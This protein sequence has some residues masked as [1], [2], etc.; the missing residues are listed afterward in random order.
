[1]TDATA[2]LAELAALDIHLRVEGGRLRYD[3]PAGVFS[4]ALKARVRSARSALMGHLAGPAPL[5]SGQERMWFLNRLEA[6]AGAYTEHLA[7]DLRGPLDLAALT[8]AV[9][10][11]VARHVPLRT[12]FRDSPSGAT[13]VPAA[14][15]PA[16]EVVPIA[17]GGLADRL[18]ILAHCAFDLATEAP[19]RFTLLRMAD[20]HHVLSVAAHHA[21]WDGWSNGVFLA[22]LAELYTARRQGRPPS[23][24]EIAVDIPTLARAERERLGTAAAQATVARLAQACQGFPTVLSLPTDRPR[25]AVADGRGA[26]L[27]VRVSAPVLAALD[28]AGRQVSATSYMV[29]LAAWALT[30]AR[31]TG[32]RRLLVGAPVAGRDSA[33]AEALIGYLSNT[34]VF[35][36]DLEGAADFATLVGRVRQAVLAG[37]DTQSVP[38][39]ALVEALAPPRSA[40]TTPLVQTVFALQPAPVTAP[41]LVGLE[42]SVLPDGN[43]AARYELML[44]LLPTADGG[45]EGSLIHATALLDQATVTRW[46]DQFLATL[47]DVPAAW[48]RPLDLVLQAAAGAAG[49]STPDSVV[50]AAGDFATGTERRLAGVWAEFLEAARIGRDDDFFLLGGHSLLLMRMVHRLAEMGLGRLSLADALANTRLSAMAAVLDRRTRAAPSPPVVPDVIAEEAPASPAQEGL[51]LARRDDPDAAN[52]MVPSLIPLDAGVGEAELRSALARLAALH[53]ALRTT[54]VEREGQVWQRVAVPGPVALDVQ[55][56]MDGERAAAFLRA[57]LARPFDLSRG[58][59]YRFHLLRGTTGASLYIV[60]DHIVTDGWSQELLA[61]DL[62]TLLAGGHPPAPEITPIAQAQAHR[63]LLAG[64]E[65]A[66]LAEYWRTA[67]DGMVLGDPPGALGRRPPAAARRG[68]KVQVR[69]EGRQ[70]RVLDTIAQGA[71]TT[72]TA[73][74]AAVVATLLARLKG[75]GREV[76]V[77]LPFACRTAPEMAGVVGCY[78]EVLPIRLSAGMDQP[79]QD[80]LVAAR[81]GIA[82]AIAHQD[83]PLSSIIADRARSGGGDAG[84]LFDA[85]VVYDDA[86]PGQEDWFAPDLNTGKYDLAFILSRLPDGGG[87]LAV[88]YDSWLYDEADARAFIDR[89]AVLMADIG[90]RPQAP[91]G[92]LEILPPAERE[93]VVG[94]FNQTALDYPRD[95]DLGSLWRSAAARHATR[96]A[97]TGTDGVTLSYAELEQRV[98]AL[99]AALAGVVGDDAAVGLALDRGA[100]AVIA[101]LALTRLGVAYLP[102]DAKLPVDAV[103]RLMADAGAR[104]VLADDGAAQRLADLGGPEGGQGKDGAAVV[105]LDHVPPA[106]T[107]ARD[108]APM[109]AVDGGS[110]AYIMF[111]SGS[112]GQ[113]KG[114]VVP[115]RG[116]ARLALDPVAVPITADDVVPQAAPLGFDAATLEIW[117]TLLNGAHLRIL[118]DDDLMDPAAL[119]ATLRQTGVSVL[120]L[121]AG[122]FNRVADEAPGAFATTRVVLTGG[123]TANPAQMARVLAACPGTRL[124]N[125][126]GPTENTTFTSVHAV[127]PADLADLAGAVP[128][129]RPIANTRVYLVDDRL[130]PVPVGVWGELL[131]AGDG[132][133]LGY[134][135][136]ADL[137]EASFVHLDWAGEERAYRS[138]DYAR[139]RHDGVLEFG[140]RRDGQVKIRGHRIET[141]A[142][143]AVLEEGADIR[144]AAVVVTGQGADRL[145]VACVVAD[146]AAA[147][148]SWRQRLGER[149]P[150]YMMPARFVLVPAL[151]VNR[152]GKVDRRAL[153][154]HVATLTTEPVVAPILA[155]PRQ[156]LVARVFTEFFPGVAIDGASDFMRLGGHSLLV[157]RL[158][159]RL[160]DE[161]GCRLPMRALFAARTVTAIAALLPAGTAPVSTGHRDAAAE[162]D[163]DATIPCQPEGMDHPLSPG[164]ERLI[165]LQR[166]FPG[167]GVYNVP[168]VFDVEGPLDQAAL[169]PAFV[170]L[171]TRHHALRLRIVDDGQAG[172]RQRLAAP[173]GLRPQWI[174]VAD[175]AAAQAYVEA[176]MMRPF[177]LGREGP[178]RAQVVRFGPERWRVLLVVHHAFCDGWSMA[179]LVRDLAAFYAV[180]TGAVGDAAVAGAPQRQMSDY[181][182]WQR[183]LAASPRGRATLARQVARL[184]PPPPPLDLPTD[185]RRPAVRGFKGGTL[186]HA[187]D[188]ALSDRLTALAHTHRAT[189]FALATALVQAL[190]YRLTGQTDLALG[191]LVAPRERPELADTVGFFVNTLVLRQAV[192]G[193]RPFRDHLA[194]TRDVCL[195]AMDDQHC[196]F[197][198]LVAAVDAPRDL[199]RNPL[200]DVLVV[201]QEAASAVPNLPGLRTAAVNLDFPMAKFDLAF[202]FCRRESGIACEIEYSAELFAPATITRLA[203]RLE[204][205]AR[206]VVADPAQTV[207]ALDLLPAAERALVVHGFNDTVRDLPVERII[208]APFLDRVAAAPAAPALVGDDFPAL[209]Y[210]GFARTAAR[211]AAR[212][213]EEGVGPGDVVGLCLPR[214]PGLLTAIFG[215]L[216]AGAAYA[217]LG[218]DQPPARLADMMDD[219][220]RPLVLA[221]TATRDRVAG[222]ARLLEID[223]ILGVDATTVPAADDWGPGPAG[224]DDL[225]YVLFTSGSTGRPKGVEI[226]HR[227]VLNRLWWMQGQFPIGAGDVVLQK[228]PVTFDVSVWELFWWS[229]TGAALALPPP[230]LERDP[231]GLAA[232]I[233]RHRVTVVHFVPSMLA[234][235]L[236]C[237][238]DGRVRISDLKTL[239]YVFASGEAL[240]PGLA[241]RFDRLLHRVHGTGLHNLYGPTEATVDVSW[242]PCTPWTGGGVPIG[243]PVANTRLYVLDGRGQPTPIGVAGE[244]HIGGVQVAR[245][246]RNRPDLTAERFIADPFAGGDPDARLYRTGDLGRWRADGSI[247]YLGRIDH[248]VKVR[249]QRIEPGEIEHALEAHPAVERA[250]VVPATNEGLTE[251]HAYLL[252]RRPV[253]PADL[254]A[255]LAGRLPEAMV[256]ARFFQMTHLPLTSS[257]KLDRKAL[258]GTPLRSAPAVPVPAI[259]PSI[260]VSA[261]ADPAALMAIESEIAG[262]WRALLPEAEFGPRDGFFTVGGNSLLV[263]RLHQRLDA[264]WPGVFAIADLFAAATVADQ[265]RR[266]AAATGVPA[267]PN[268]SVPNAVPPGGS[269]SPVTVS[270]PVGALPAVPSGAIAV[271]GLA[272]RVAGAETLAD[273]WTDVAAGVDRFRPL[274]AGRVADVHALYA[275]LGLPVPATFRQAAY[276]EEVLGFDCRRYRLSPADAALIDPEQRLFLDVALRALEDAGRGGT[277]LD[278]AKVGVFVGASGPGP[279]RAA[280]LRAVEPQR[281]EQA[282]ALTVPSNVATRLSFQHNWRGPAALVDTACSASLSAL[283]QGVR[284]LRSGDCDWALVGGAKAILLP[285]G[286][287]QRLTID[288]S[289][290]R[291][292]AFAEG[293]DGTGMGEGAV[294]L[295][296]RPLAAALAA[297]DPIHAVILGTAVNQD[298]ASSGMAAPNPTAQAEVIRAAAADAGVSLASLSYVEAHGTGTALGDPIEIQG[299]TTAFAADTAEVGFA[300]VGSAKGNY[301]HL[302]GAAGVLGLARAILSLTHDHAP[303]QPHFTAP[304]P[305]IAFDRAPVAVPRRAMALADRGGPRRAGISAFG[306]SGVNVHAVVEAAP[307]RVAAPATGRWMAVGL[308]AAEPEALHGYADAMVAALRAR[309][310][311]SLEEIART[312]TEGR[313]TLPARLAVAVRD[314]GDLMARLAVFVAAPAAAGD[315]VLVGVAPAGPPGARWAA[316]GPDQAAA[317]AAARAFVTGAVLTWDATDATTGRAHLPA[318]PW[319]GAA[320]RPICRRRRP[321]CRPRPVCSVRR[322]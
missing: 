79:F 183:A 16:L 254:V 207:D 179:L 186:V 302:D 252:L 152:N 267:T 229:W 177:D 294:A 8:A 192:A 36:I 25:G 52:W 191:T 248:Q 50:P 62:H 38:F 271:V 280:L 64:P 4:D 27:P 98:G 218:A 223:Q 94:R 320:W 176:E 17:A 30:L 37:L 293:A 85:V 243:R 296:L 22:E 65:G 263:I 265:A 154:R 264:R 93:R 19:A 284:A 180:G 231:V 66:R 26:A 273:L 210:R 73:A 208:T 249:G 133:A 55:D 299:L 321:W 277:A 259:A 268:L 253:G 311:W 106:P 157:M 61:R 60:A 87:L 84:S 288:S 116:V 63:T 70:G 213:R 143:E 290:G 127:T 49:P 144:A 307:A 46:R 147:E 126:Y 161:T 100:P 74:F 301:G 211:L 225:A 114:V 266:V 235:F 189:P 123:E 33:A 228:T 2:L 18:A 81:Q 23:L 1:M 278:D 67:L 286:E 257:G 146:D 238:E 3:A 237:V 291:T 236:A 134:A 115:H 234:A 137:T 255:H 119:A 149:L 315:L 215:V 227:A 39:E 101:T 21:A 298:G 82:V 304:N 317:E 242:H 7:L 83:Y 221:T 201:W 212:L 224:P 20:D 159:V 285:P 13:Q 58:P 251:L 203:N 151:P 45:L 193:S 217:P 5:S 190:L 258:A 107:Q 173:G 89:L 99:S 312:L 282:F 164:Q 86:G 141:G 138:G 226:I 205:L 289:S 261:D 24:P 169:E 31:L 41:A 76:A 300:W 140:G 47:A 287:D 57:E 196:P 128:I 32:Q 204:T 148:P 96:P 195:Q 145:L 166:L 54:L 121:T 281:V 216:M 136:R 232:F 75:D 95:A 172:L 35:P 124:I 113:P 10:A 40:A 174:E 117:G 209:D 182:V 214:G 14:Q 29:L 260:T 120:W 59:L 262:F 11:I 222:A 9:E 247:D 158:A 197:E 187:F 175:A 269:V 28:Q 132:L 295:L 97:L 48:N 256:P 314:R 292:L 130:R 206:A 135:N 44:N 43:V 246:Y 71:R 139:W 108:I 250:A 283:H 15:A 305:K 219:L 275:A 110:P 167:S 118:S 42:V 306:L 111:T 309:P 220:G 105:R 244:I 318:A 181:A 274:P 239:R 170:A 194:E 297:R 90:A 185:H 313:D 168:V 319:P 72:P 78:A 316:V 150:S 303:P 240:D 199:G 308:S 131:C 6:G 103:R 241:D 122:L 56:G 165:V 155:D 102:L 272:V 156:R 77:G 279:W 68:R 53:P 125:A 200:F 233:A 129:G 34:V 171:E 276:L 310:D 80:H 153:A 112:T 163:G 160:A 69:M 92:D 12:L 91:L 184:T 322:R 178:A 230:G 142:I 245:G 188:G 104:L 88:E 162:L 270:A 51:W 202:H 109:R 198:A